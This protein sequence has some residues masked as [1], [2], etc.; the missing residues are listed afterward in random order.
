MLRV[1]SLHKYYALVG[2]TFLCPLQTVFEGYVEIPLY[3][4]I[5]YISTCVVF[6]SFA[7]FILPCMPS[8]NLTV[9]WIFIKLYS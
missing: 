7:M 9:L 5:L 2:E 4:Y 1:T 3:I 8:S 6:L